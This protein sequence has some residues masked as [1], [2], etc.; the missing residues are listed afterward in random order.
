MNSEIIIGKSASYEYFERH[1]HSDSGGVEVYPKSR[2]TIG[3]G[4]RFRTEFELV[5]GRVG[6]IEID[7]G[8]VCEKDSV[9]EV[10]SRISGRCDDLIM[11]REKGELV[12]KNSRGVLISKIAIRDE[13]RAEV[14]NELMASAAHARG[15][16]D[17]FEIV[18]DRAIAKAV[19]EIQVN[20]PQ[21]HITHEAAIGS[22]DTKQMQT[23]MSRGLSE[24]DAVELIISGLL[25]KSK[26]P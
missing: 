2:V 15:H 20:H 4:S 17:C 16:V 6:L 3:E 8:V 24:E 19:P 5:K 23:L 12:G 9:M 18:Q 13:A 10:E 26:N 11:I 7:Y 22:V 1:I 14:Y 21:A 25:S